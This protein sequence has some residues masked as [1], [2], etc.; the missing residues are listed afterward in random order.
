MGEEGP[1]LDEEVQRVL[2]AIESLGSP[3]VPAAARA[4]RLT[5]LLDEWPD[6]HSRVREMRQDA[7]KELQDDGL[8]LRAISAETGVSFGRVR[9]IIQGITKRPAKKSAAKH[10]TPDKEHEVA[11]DEPET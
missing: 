2:E 8:S 5:Q 6:T 3:E 9:E 4:K 11:A 1:Q 10:K 7:M